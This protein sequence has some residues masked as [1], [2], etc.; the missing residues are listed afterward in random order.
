MRGYKAPGDISIISM[1]Q[2]IHEVDD[3]RQDRGTF[4]T[5]SPAV[6]APPIRLKDEVLA[7]RRFDLH[8]IDVPHVSL[9]GIITPGV[10]L[11][12]QGVIKMNSMFGSAWHIVFLLSSGV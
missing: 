10:L 1:V 6:F 7:R 8:W 12:S 9:A 2:G 4:S 11:Y 5:I 3:R